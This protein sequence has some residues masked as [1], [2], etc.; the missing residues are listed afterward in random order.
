MHLLGTR[1]ALAL[2]A[3]FA[4]A[5]ASGCSG[6]DPAYVGFLLASDEGQRW[7]E[8]DEPAFRAELEELCIGCVYQTRNAEGSAE[9]QAEQFSELVDAGAKVV[10]LNAVDAAAA[11]TLVTEHP[12]VSVIAYDRFVEGAAHFVSVDAAVAGTLA[13]ETALD[14]VA[15]KKPSGASASVLVLRGPAD[16]P[17]AEAQAA[18]VNDVLTSRGATV[19]ATLTPTTRAGTEATA[20]VRANASAVGKVDAVIGGDDGQAA[21]VVSALSDLGVTGDAWPYVTG[22]DADLSAVRRVVAGKQG[23]TVHTHPTE[24]AEQAA[25]LAVDLLAGDDPRDNP[26]LDVVDHRGVASVILTPGPVTR[27][28]VANTVVRDRTWSIEQICAGDVMDHCA[29]LGL[30]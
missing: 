26:D 12:D 16:D 8:L 25:A 18:A 23:M 2:T 17:D 29:E 1:T 6:D 13:A 30:Y 21:G 5:G 3:M 14:A 24:M 9:R 27:T 10:V 22:R 28:T 7:S 19:R 15:A 20:F 11:A 4:A